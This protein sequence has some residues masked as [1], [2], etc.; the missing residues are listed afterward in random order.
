MVA[1]IEC[2]VFSKSL[3]PPCNLLID[4]GD[5]GDFP[6]CDV[7]DSYSYNFDNSASTSLPK[8]NNENTRMVCEVFSKLTLTL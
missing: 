7:G 5:I 1:D 3:D 8:I 2:H 4:L 6:S